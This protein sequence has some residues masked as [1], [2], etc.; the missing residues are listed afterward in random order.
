[1]GLNN[2]GTLL[3]N[4]I[5]G[6]GKTKRV[7]RKKGGEGEMMEQM[8]QNFNKL[9]TEFKCRM[10]CDQIDKKGNKYVPLN[11]Q[12]VNQMEEPV[13]EQLQQG[14]VR[15][16]KK[17]RVEYKKRL[18]NMTVDKLKGMARSK[19]LKITVKRNGKTEYVK[20]DTLVKKLCDC[21]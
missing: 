18:V 17:Q 15:K 1:M 2:S 20:K 3:G 19:K 13:L 10:T 4:S 7:N 8:E 9:N 12:Q 21:Y 5:I 14:G 6:G 16:T 11:N